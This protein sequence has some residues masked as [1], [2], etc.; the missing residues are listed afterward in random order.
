MSDIQAFLFTVLTLYGLLMT[1]LFAYFARLA[2]KQHVAIMLIVS[3]P[4]AYE[5]AKQLHAEMKGAGN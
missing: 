1:V 5:F 3:K 4:E 2:Y